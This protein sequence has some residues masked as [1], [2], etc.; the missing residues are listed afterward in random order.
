MPAEAWST[1]ASS[2]PSLVVGLIAAAAAVI[3]ALLNRGGAR[4]NAL[5]D[6]LQE[7]VKDALA[8]AEKV[9]AR[10][11]AS[12][13][14]ERIRDDYIHTLRDHID[15]GKKPPSPPWPEGLTN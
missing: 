7:Q 9:E 4:E 1:L 12:L 3:V 6:Q 11:D 10:L 14:R 5:I 13:K 8:R 2:I 15:Q